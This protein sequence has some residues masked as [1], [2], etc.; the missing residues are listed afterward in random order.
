MKQKCV[1][2]QSLESDIVASLALYN[3]RK[4]IISTGISFF[5]YMLQQCFDYSGLKIKL[6]CL[7]NLL[8]DYHHTYEDVGIVI[9]KLLLSAVNEYKPFRYSSVYIPMYGSLVRCSLDFYGR[10]GFWYDN[11]FINK[12]CPSIDL[13]YTFFNSVARSSNLS[14]HIDFLKVNS[15]YNAVEAAFKSFGICCW[16][17]FNMKNNINSSEKCVRELWK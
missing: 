1:R 13:V 14:I 15:I 17:S 9:G 8:V 4:T 5:D 10:S 16:L 11:K 3:H 12:F 2:I 6:C 7:S